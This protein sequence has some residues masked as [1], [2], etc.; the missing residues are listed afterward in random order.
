MHP[1]DFYSRCLSPA[2]RNYDVVNKELLAV[3]LALEEWRDWLEGSEQSFVVWTD[4]KNLS[5]LRSAK[6]WW[7]LVL[8]RFHICLP[9]VLVL[10]TQSQ[11]LSP[12]SQTQ[13]SPI[14]NLE[15]FCP[16]EFISSVPLSARSQVLQWGHSSK[17]TCHPGVHRTLSFIKQ[18]FWWPSMSQ[19]TDAFVSA[20]SGITLNTCWPFATS[21][22]TTQTMVTDGIGFCHWSPTF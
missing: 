7:A 12:A 15:P 4:H 10:T 9:I 11:T 5:Y 20:C 8:G 13:R 16:P 3:V 17:L 2:E 21:A 1:C 18:Q 22:G 14:W 19:D 6:R